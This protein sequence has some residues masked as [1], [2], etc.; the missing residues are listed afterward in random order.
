MNFF[1][2]DYL[3]SNKEIEAWKVHVAKEKDIFVAKKVKTIHPSGRQNGEG[4][5][6]I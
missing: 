5:F 6:W 4:I 2:Q 1:Q 3:M